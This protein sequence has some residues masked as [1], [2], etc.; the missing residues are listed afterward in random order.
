MGA[1]NDD[2][3]DGHPSK[4]GKGKTDEA[5]WFTKGCKPGPGRPKGAKNHKTIWAEVSAEKVQVNV[6]GKAKHLTKGE[7]KYHQ[8]SS[9]AASG[10][11]KAIEMAIALDEQWQPPLVVPS[12]PGDLDAD[13]ATLA[14]YIALQTKFKKSTGDDA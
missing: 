12:T 5:T 4:W 10:V 14:D 7:L 6:A 9:K 13:L 2:G 1:K 8:L 3:S 11:I